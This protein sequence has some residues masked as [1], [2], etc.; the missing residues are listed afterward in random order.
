MT[1][2]NRFLIA[3]TFEVKA[4]RGLSVEGLTDTTHP[5]IPA[6]KPYVFREPRRDV[7]A[8]LAEPAGN[9]LLLTD[10]TGSGK[11]SLVPQVAARLNWPVQEV[12]CH[13]RMELTDLVGQ[14]LLI[15]GEARFVHGPLAVAARDGHLLVLD[16]MDVMDAAELAGVNEIVEGRPW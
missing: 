12:T 10:P 9:A 8:F 6:K 11:T 13:G 16:E 5:Q 15:E 2:T 7:L 14:F 1:Q 4:P 3:E